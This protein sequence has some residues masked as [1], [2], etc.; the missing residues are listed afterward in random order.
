MLT[1][2]GLETI[3]SKTA[4]AIGPITA[5]ELSVHGIEAIMCDEYSAEGIV[6][7]LIKM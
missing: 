4:L 6:S 2:V 5:K 3:K 1:M 7:K